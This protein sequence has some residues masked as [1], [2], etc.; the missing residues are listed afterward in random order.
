MSREEIPKSGG[1]G[2]G[3]LSDFQADEGAEITLNA[4]LAG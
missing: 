1:C 2:K 3:R 4:E